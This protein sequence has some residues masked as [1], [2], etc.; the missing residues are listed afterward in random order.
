MVLAIIPSGV[1]KTLG[2]YVIM[3]HNL[4]CRHGSA[5]PPAATRCQ[6]T[7]LLMGT[8]WYVLRQKTD[9]GP[10]LE[11]AVNAQQK[12]STSGVLFH[13]NGKNHP[14]VCACILLDFLLCVEEFNV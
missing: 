10:L 4:K 2:S 3:Q 7:A 11:L 9:D 1:L 6:D 13:D 5:A 12:L 8:R 14:L